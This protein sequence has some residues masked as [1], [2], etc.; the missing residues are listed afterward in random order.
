MWFRL[1]ILPIVFIAGSMVSC[2][3][4]GVTLSPAPGGGD[5]Q[6]KSFDLTGLGFSMEGFDYDVENRHLKITKLNHDTALTQTGDVIKK[7]LFWDGIRGL[8]NVVTGSWLDGKALDAGVESEQIAA[9]VTSD[10]IA[11]DVATTKILTEAAP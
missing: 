3:S 2:S 4:M 10:Q 7:A 5:T 11:A 6:L 1:A 9:G 8:V